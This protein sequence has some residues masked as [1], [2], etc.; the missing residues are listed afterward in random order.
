MLK[1]NMQT[2][3]YLE[4]GNMF[5]ESTCCSLYSLSLAVIKK[6]KIK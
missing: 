6:K 1:E 3:Y 4:I 5:G 2:L